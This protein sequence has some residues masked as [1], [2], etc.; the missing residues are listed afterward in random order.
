M[1]DREITLHTEV[2]TAAQLRRK[3]IGLRRIACVNE[4]G[5]L[6]RVAARE[7]RHADALDEMA[8]LVEAAPFASWDRGPA[9]LSRMLLERVR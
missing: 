6:E 8:R 7:R 5:G 4:M 9:C 2:S 3:S 1:S